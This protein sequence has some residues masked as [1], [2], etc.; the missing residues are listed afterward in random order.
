MANTTRTRKASAAATAGMS[1]EAIAQQIATAIIAR[2][3]PPGTWLREEALGRAYGVSRTKVHAALVMLGKDRLIE[4][5]PDKGCF[6]CQPSVQE[7]RE[8]FGVRR[9]LEAE[10]IRLL[11]AR[12]NTHDYALLERHIALERQGLAHNNAPPVGD[13]AHEKLLGDF[14]VVLAETA[15]NRTVAELVREMVAR[16]SLIAMLYHTSNDPQCS[17]HEHEDLLRLCRQGDAEA[18]VRC[19]DAHLLRIEANLQLQVAPQRPPDIVNAL[20]A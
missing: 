10:V 7:A 1:V 20:L 11:V 6:V 8:V 3:L 17:S 9:M 16:S 18:A 15:G 12:A 2:R 5:I 4:N 19:M 13:A 14:H